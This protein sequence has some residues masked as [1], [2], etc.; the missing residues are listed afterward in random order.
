MKRIRK[1]LTKVMEERVKHISAS[2]K[3][4]G[5]SFKE[6][7]EYKYL[8]RLFV[9][10]DLFAIYKQTILGPA[11]FAIQPIMTTLVFTLV[12]GFIARI[13][14]NGY[15]AFIFYFS[16]L[17]C[18]NCFSIIMNKVSN[19]FIE[20]TGVYSKVYFPRLTAPIAASISSF[21][22]TLI[23]LSILILVAIGYT[24]SGTPIPM[25]YRV[26][27]AFM[28]LLVSAAMGFGFGLLVAA[29]TVKYRDLIYFLS[30][31]MLLWMYATPVIYPLDMIPERFQ[32]LLFSNPMTGIVV[33][34]KYF[35]FGIGSPN[36]LAL[37]YSIVFAV[38]VILI[39]IACYSKAQKNF[40]D[41]I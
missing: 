4:S 16:G 22:I 28:L 31:A 8:I 25:T 39:G 35:L 29:G 23:Q 18:W 32:L 15:P 5:T 33:N 41:T 27:F 38:C 24:I 7:I 37:L 9:K 1:E 10:R 36:L 13:P 40:V 3:G 11:W 21:T 34:F 14:T 2:S 30:F 20:N 12:F 19:T 6:L 26:V 17:V